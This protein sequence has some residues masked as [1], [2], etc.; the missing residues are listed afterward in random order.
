LDQQV[1]ETSTHVLHSLSLL[2]TGL[3]FHLRAARREQR[4]GWW[5]NDRLYIVLRQLANGSRVRDEVVPACCQHGRRFMG[6]PRT[7]TTR[8]HEHHQPERV[9]DRVGG[10]HVAEECREVGGQH[11]WVGCGDRGGCAVAAVARRRTSSGKRDRPDGDGGVSAA[12]GVVWWGG[13]MRG[14]R[15]LYFRF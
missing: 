3:L 11:R 13:L 6:R 8:E 5:R 4:K 12:F 1:S 9:S 10:V 14:K 7:T 2:L 15:P